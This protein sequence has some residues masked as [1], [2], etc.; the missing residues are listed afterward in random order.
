MDTAAP[1][2]LSVGAEQESTDTAIK[3]HAGASRARHDKEGDTEN[4]PQPQAD[5]PGTHGRENH[6][7]VWIV[8]DVKDHL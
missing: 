6:G 1:S 8:K 5:P 3:N 4:I 7:M 2:P